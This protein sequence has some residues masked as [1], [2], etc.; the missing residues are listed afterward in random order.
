MIKEWFLVILCYGIDRCVIV[1]QVS[2]GNLGG[3]EGGEV[4]ASGL[5]CV[6][7]SG[8]VFVLPKESPIVEVVAELCRLLLVFGEEVG[9]ATGER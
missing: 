1:V 6:P 2:V 5:V 4:H 7:F 9:E 3:R 8:L